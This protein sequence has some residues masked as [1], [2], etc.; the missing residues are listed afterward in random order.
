[1]IRDIYEN[2]FPL[3]DLTKMQAI[4][5]MMQ[6]IYENLLNFRS[7]QNWGLQITL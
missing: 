4:H 2:Q 1:M 6:D 7:D 3:I 5:C